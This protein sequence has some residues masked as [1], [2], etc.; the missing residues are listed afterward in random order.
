MLGMGMV[1]IDERPGTG[2]CSSCFTPGRVLSMPGG[3]LA[4][5]RTTLSE[6]YDSGPRAVVIR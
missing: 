6:G 2:T 4:V 1:G 5:P 3:S